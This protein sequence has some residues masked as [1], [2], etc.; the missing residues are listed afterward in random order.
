[1]KRPYYG[2]LVVGMSMIS[3]MIVLGTVFSSFGLFVLPVSQELGLSRA[4][5]NS[6]LILL[7]LGGAVAAPAIGRLVDR[8]PMK[9][10]ML[11]SAL[12]L[13]AC[14]VGLGLSHSLWIDMAILLV[15]LPIVVQGAGNMTMPVLI[16]RWFEARRGRAM[17]LGMMGLAFGAAILPPIVGFLIERQGW[18]IALIISGCLSALILTVLFLFVRDRP[19][20]GEMTDVAAARPWLADAPPAPAHVYTIGE[21]LRTPRFWLIAISS[22]LALSVTQGVQVS[23][24]PLALDNGFDMVAAASLI[25]A[26]GAGSFGG[27][28][29]L[30]LF[31]DR[32]N[33][34][35]LLAGLYAMLALLA[36]VP[37]LTRDYPV[38]LVMAFGFG[39]C[40]AAM[41]VFY[42][43]L[44][45]RFGTASFGTAQGLS[46]PFIALI[47]AASIRF[48]GEV[49]DKTGHY[50][51][52]FYAYC[53]VMLVA[54]AMILSTR[55]V[56]R[57]SLAAPAL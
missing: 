17:A 57:P 24:V 16:A 47:G 13:G 28:L 6:A 32:I 40:G 11:L 34:E 56:A 48:A 15:P 1:M 53:G 33:R 21:L 54:A 31:A 10:L 12:G 45:D 55:Y 9:P 25:S 36:C 27:K 46:M 29:L 30:A 8:V 26:A 5:M 22:A 38:L 50:D 39:V 14:L 23:L 20:P 7:S 2:W 19:G 41:A 4:N 18:R 35:V 51:L 37:L 52:M 42:A 3:M 49:Y 43:L 44:A